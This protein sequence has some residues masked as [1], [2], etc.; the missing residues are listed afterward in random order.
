MAPQND[1][2][3]N[4]TGISSGNGFDNNKSEEVS[5]ILCRVG[6]KLS[7]S[8]LSCIDDISIVEKELVK[9]IKLSAKLVNNSSQLLN[10]SGD[11]MRKASINVLLELISNIKSKIYQYQ[12]ENSETLVSLNKSG[13]NFGLLIN[14]IKNLRNNLQQIKT[15]IKNIQLINKTY[16]NNVKGFSA[17]DTNKIETILSKIEVVCPVL[18]ENIFN[19]LT[20]NSQL[21]EKLDALT[22]R[23]I[24]KITCL[25][26]KASN[27]VDLIN[28]Q[29][30][31][32]NKIEKTNKTLLDNNIKQLD[33]FYTDIEKLREIIDLSIQHHR[34]LS[35]VFKNNDNPDIHANKFSK[36]VKEKGS[37]SVVSVVELHLAH[38]LISSSKLNSIQ[39]VGLTKYSKVL[40]N[41][42]NISTN[43]GSLKNSNDSQ[44][45]EFKH[46]AELLRDIVEQTTIYLN[47]FLNFE[48]DI[49]TEIK[50]VKQ[51]FDLFL[52]VDL[53]DNSIEQKIIQKVSVENFLTNP[54]ESIAKEA[55]ELLKLYA[56]NHFEKSKIKKIFESTIEE[57][58]SASNIKVSGGFCYKGLPPLDEMINNLSET[59]NKL[60]SSIAD[61]NE[62]HQYNF[63]SSREIK[64]ATKETS[65]HLKCFSVFNSFL[66][67][68]IIE[69]SSL[70]DMYSY[71]NESSLITKSAKSM[72]D[73]KVHYTEKL[74]DIIESFESQYMQKLNGKSPNYISKQ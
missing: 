67:E 47:E 41:A 9:D 62:L 20:H 45:V 72:D 64:L 10:H 1:S 56:D 66:D 74:F 40:N 6:E 15:I 5:D 36:N 63:E 31:N 8:R 7:N 39:D 48:K 13:S 26:E 53:M 43:Y 73:I 46:T 57:L 22:N 54:E 52:D 19:I 71:K 18:E 17:D 42:S 4:R 50:V 59:F 32:L 69:I 16:N 34:T 60:K 58:L 25:L 55:Q 30:E 14:P 21:Q 65:I 11:K 51:L 61:I 38:L 24:P 37:E 68:C 23:Y 27:H 49:N 70:Y 28:K 12:N 35:E 3:K 33:S 2:E 29:F 44:P